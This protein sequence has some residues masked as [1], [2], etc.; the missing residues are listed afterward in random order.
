[1]VYDITMELGI[2]GV[3]VLHESPIKVADHQIWPG[4]AS[5]M[6]QQYS[7]C[8]PT[9]KRTQFLY[10]LLESI[11]GQQWLPAF[12]DLEIIIADNDSNASAENVATEWSASTK[13]RL[14]YFVVKE[15]GL[16]H[17]RNAL[18]KAAQFENVVLIDDDQI[19]P[20][21]FFKHLAQNWQSQSSDV[22]AAQFTIKC[23]FAPLFPY[24]ISKL[25]TW[26]I[27][28]EFKIN[29]QD[30]EYM[31]TNGAIFRR[32]ASQKLG[33]IFDAEL[34]LTSGEDTQF[35]HS[36]KKNGR[37]VGLKDTVI[38][39][40]FNLERSS[41]FYWYASNLHKG[42]NFTSLLRRQNN[43][44]KCCL[45]LMKATFLLLA[46]LPLLPVALVLNRLMFQTLACLMLRQLGKIIGWAGF[47]PKFYK[48]TGVTRLCDS[49]KK[50]RN[51]PLQ[52]MKMRLKAH[53]KLFDFLM[54]FREDV[55][56]PFLNLLGIK[57]IQ[58]ARAIMAHEILNKLIL[59][60][61]RNKD[62]LEVSGTQ[63]QHLLCRSYKSLKYPAFDLTKDVLSEKFD[64]I[65]L[66]QVLEH[67]VAP[68]QGCRN[69]KS[70]LKPNGVL[71]INTPFL[72]KVHNC[73]V[74]CW[75]WTKTGLRILL[76]NVGFKSEHVE[77]YSWGNKLVVFLNLFYFWPWITWL[78]RL[79]N[80]DE[81]PVV[82]WA[83]ACNSEK[84][85]PYRGE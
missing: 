68:E 31:S 20:S 77:V 85:K 12:V 75:R 82:V 65:L 72:I 27:A 24:E 56:W 76:E 50:S 38:Y 45:H 83:F 47:V 43:Y 53:A 15:R 4:D 54:L 66:D 5:K 79:K 69:L 35:F 39:E 21:D 44:P 19:I 60:D 7:I 37:L 81:F 33:L 34:N 74:D 42:A 32:S 80:D 18:L 3:F 62:V 23:V 25:A 71:M 28:I 8:I 70:M 2:H 48:S 1:M 73:P 16:S 49:S 64:I 51:T 6:T 26:L 29:G 46:I 59:L 55:F 9:F 10:E 30:I 36:L 63:Y 67:V 61:Y 22:V 52:A 84:V 17:V 78:H 13:I 14:K 11:S 40:R 58:W 57:R 41:V